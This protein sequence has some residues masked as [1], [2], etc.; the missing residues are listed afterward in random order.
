MICPFL[1][2]ERV[3]KEVKYDPDGKVIE[4]KE[5]PA[6]EMVEC[7]KADCYVYD[8]SLGDCSLLGL[9]RSS[10]SMEALLKLTRDMRNAFGSMK[11]SAEKSTEEQGKLMETLS[12][13]QRESG[14]ATLSVVSRIDEDFKKMNE[15]VSEMKRGLDSL[16]AKLGEYSGDIQASTKES[17]ERL[18]GKLD[19]HS[20][21]ITDIAADSV[22]RLQEGLETHS[23]RLID[24]TT[25]LSQKLA[26]RLDSHTEMVGA[27]G[28]EWKES[29]KEA[30][31]ELTAGLG[32]QKEAVDSAMGESRKLLSS[33]LNAIENWSEKSGEKFAEMTARLDDIRSEMGERA[34][35]QLEEQKR[36]NSLLEAVSST[37]SALSERMES[38][39]DRVAEANKEMKE[40]VQAVRDE[41]EEEKRRKIL[42]EARAHND[43][44]V[45]LYFR[46]SYAGAVEEFEKAIELDPT[47]AEAHSNMA[48]SLTGLGKDDE[49]ASSFK[50]A[51]EID[52]DMA[53]AYNNLG[54]LHFKKKEYEQAL[55]MFEEAVKKREDYPNAYCNLGSAYKLLDMHDKALAAWEHVLKLDPDNQKAK[56]AIEETRGV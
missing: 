28:K 34:G 27:M 31:Q 40:F 56:R 15:S 52:P 23:S 38:V 26:E 9:S 48:L 30:V 39:S 14:V 16:L 47:M 36:G 46:R 18:I 3:T 35:S 54:L 24:A 53:E 25:E 2:L 33:I 22:R 41:R 49:A 55:S 7:L 50:R 10:E 42:E 29:V 37:I 5:T 1:S 21:R 8:Q 45:A 4:D 51:L 13:A 44:G 12:K 43:R 17:M 11:D 32:E 20:A 19:G 6:R